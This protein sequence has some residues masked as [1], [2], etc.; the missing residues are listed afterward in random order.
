MS[1]IV[2]AGR[3]LAALTCALLL[4]RQD[5][6]VRIIG[7]ET[8]GRRWLILPEAVAELL[9]EVWGSEVGVL[10]AAW[11]VPR[12]HV[13][14]GDNDRQYVPAPSHALDGAALNQRLAAYLARNCGDQVRFDHRTP[15]SANP[16]PPGDP[17]DGRWLITATPVP[18]SAR[19]GVVGR[20]HIITAE[21]RITPTCDSA[22]CRMETS[23]QG[24]VYLAPVGK[25]LA[26]VQAMV[27]GPVHRPVR[28]LSDLLG[29]TG[30]GA[31]LAEPP[32]RASVVR[33]APALL[34]PPCGPGWL[35]VGAAAIQFDPL[36][37]SGAAQAVRTAILATAAI[38]AIDRGHC[39]QDVL[40]HYAARLHTAFT[41]HLRSCLDRYGATFPGEAW[42]D[43]VD[44]T[45]LALR[46][47][48]D[49]AQMKF[50]LSG[51][52]LQLRGGERSYSGH[53]DG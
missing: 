21:A 29:Q 51:F 13:R 16:I 50:L 5:R 32:A 10:D 9:G 14:W 15:L 24:W 37:G 2:V 18:D 4:A 36:S 48:A 25:E 17:A 7:P 47:P 49:D 44:A 28:L 40:D 20:R 43:E 11:S 12:R 23:S 27:P 26:L 30:L 45:A 53:S 42:Q 52:R 3:G 39:A 22:T 46:G 33:A 34:A 35:A 38:D 31:Q 8:T 41:V 1:E 19:F 6:R